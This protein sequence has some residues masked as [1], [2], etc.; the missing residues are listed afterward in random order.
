MA[1]HARLRIDTGLAIHFCDPQSPWQRGTNENTN[2]LLRQYSRRAQT[3]ASTALTILPQWPLRLM[4]DHERLSTGGLQPKLST[5]YY[6]LLNTTA[7][8]RSLEP[9]QYLSIRYTDRLAEA[10]IEPSVGSTGDSYDNA[11]AETVI[12]L[13]KTEEIH[14]RGPWKGLED[15]EFATLEWARG[16]TAAACS[17]RSATCRRQSSRTPTMTVRPAQSVWRFSRNELSGK[18]GTVQH[19]VQSR[20]PVGPKERPRRIQ[21]CEDRRFSLS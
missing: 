4:E 6:D 2:G 8:R 11:L 21:E 17:N 3:S 16:T 5:I 15:V 19:R 20:S 13:F 12:G 7:L 9:A 14:R 10:G 18:P 1:R